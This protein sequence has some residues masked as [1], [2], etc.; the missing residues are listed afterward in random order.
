VSPGRQLGL[1]WGAV[2]AALVALSP[3]APRF[4]ATLPPCLFKLLTGLPCPSCG[5]TRAALD[6]ARFDPAAAFAVS[7]LAAG[8]W[9]LLIAGGLVAGVASLAR[10]EVPEP[11]NDL[12]RP[13]RWI[14]IGAL[15]A[16]WAYLIRTGA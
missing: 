5:A 1:L 9:T 4:A 7:P 11:P 16:N 8:G 6:L 15:L 10:F 3:L 14:V 12:P 2:A 13:L